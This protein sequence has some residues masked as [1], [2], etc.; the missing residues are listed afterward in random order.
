MYNYIISVITN[1]IKKYLTP[2]PS[3]E[4]PRYAAGREYG[5]G[6]ISTFDVQCS[7]V[8]ILTEN[9][10]QCSELEFGSPLELMN[11]SQSGVIGN[12]EEQGGGQRW[13]LTASNNLKE[14]LK[15]E[16]EAVEKEEREEEKSSLCT[17]SILLVGM[18][19]PHPHPGQIFDKKKS[20]HRMNF[21]NRHKRDTSVRLPVITA[22]G[23]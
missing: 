9:P 18:G 22:I 13:A 4:I 11:S 12:H 7:Q 19:P 1:K 8:D 23:S 5:L 3:S 10:E 17:G 2:R 20:R 21:I 14:K 6:H 15:E 16:E